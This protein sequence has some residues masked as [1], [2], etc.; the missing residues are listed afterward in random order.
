MKDNSHA[1]IDVSIIDRYVEQLDWEINENSN[2]T[3]SLQ[4]LHNYIS[5]EVNEEYWLTRIYP[6]YIQKAHDE[7]DIHI[8]QL[9]SLSVYCVGWDLE[10]LLREGFCGVRGK[11]ESKPPKHLRSALGQ[12]VNF[13]YTL[14][15]ES[16]GAQAFSNFDTLMAP[17][18]AYDNLSDEAIEQA[19]QEFIFNMNI[20]TRVGFQTPFTNISFDLTVPEHLKNTPIIIGGKPQ[21][22]TYGEFQT[23]MDRF[24]VAFTKMMMRG[25]AKGRIFTFP[26]PTYSITKDFDWENPRYKSIWELSAKF[27]TPYFSNFI[28]SDLSPEDVRSMCCRLRLDNREL[29][30]RGG[31]FFGASPMTGSIGTVTINL[32]KIGFLSANEEDFFKRLCSLME[33]AR[34]SLEIK[35]QLSEEFT[36]QRLYPYTK[37]YLREIK[38]KHGAYW[39]NHFSTIGLIGMNEASLNLLG[40]TI[41]TPQGQQFAERVLDTMNEMLKN[42]QEETGH[43][44]NL[45]A[46]P[47]ES[48]TY[49]L[50]CKD[51]KHYPQI[52]VANDREYKEH[53]APPFYTNS[54]HLPVDYTDDIFEALELQ[55]TLQTKYT[56]GTVLHFFTGEK[57]GDPDTVKNL[58]QKICTKYRLPYFTFTPTFSICPHHGYLS[59]E[60]HECP[61]CS[62]PC[63]IYSRIVGYV[64]PVEQW[65]EGKRTEFSMRKTFKIED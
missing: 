49:R 14:Q 62:S 7:G 5:T 64:R 58:V 39:F 41:A 28:N 50:A 4:G 2:M 9:N 11:V 29:K 15:G 21:E 53:N 37:Y 47:A 38:E 24:N 59:G 8:H 61:T 19:I 46:T 57:I 35:R 44:F 12:S 51:K 42:F 45:E 6:E 16:A 20:P 1:P 26:I 31:G 23:E 43:C 60:K 17:Y 34:D 52:I 18:I 10:K 33:I 36:E 22:Q 48:T 54:S 55:D 65:N 63:E 30:R 3:Y 32:P 56:G 27:G 25:D 40:S 13:L